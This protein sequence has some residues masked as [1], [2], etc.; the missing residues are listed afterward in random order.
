MAEHLQLLM[1]ELEEYRDH[2][3][4]LRSRMVVVPTVGIRSDLLS[5]YAESKRTEAA[6]WSV[7]TVRT[8]EEHLRH[9]W[10]RSRHEFK[11]YRLLT[12]LEF[13]Y[14]WMKA[15]LETLRTGAGDQ[16]EASDLNWMT[17]YVAR[18][19]DDSIRTWKLLHDY[20]I[21]RLPPPTNLLPPSKQRDDSLQ[22]LFFRWVCRYRETAC[23]HGW[24]SE[25]EL[26]ALLLDKLGSKNFMSRH[27]T[28]ALFL[29]LPWQEKI[30]HDYIREYVEAASAAGLD[31]QKR[32]LLTLPPEDV[33]E[34]RP[35]PRAFEY[36]DTNRE[37][38]AAAEQAREWLEQ[39]VDERLS[40]DE[41][42]AVRIG[43]VVPNLA[44][45]K[46]RMRRQFLATFCPNGH[47]ACQTPSFTIQ[48]RQSLADMTVCAEILS[49]LRILHARSIVYSKAR[50]LAH[51][52][53]FS[54]VV[55]KRRLD[56]LRE[57]TNHDQ[58]IDSEI[59]SPWRGRTQKKNLADWMKEFEDLL[60]E[61]RNSLKA[62]RR[63]DFR[64][65]F[66]AYLRTSRGLR[67]DRLI[68]E[69]TARDGKARK[70]VIGTAER[71]WMRG[72]KLKPAVQKR[73]RDLDA[74]SDNPDRYQVL[75]RLL[76]LEQRLLEGAEEEPAGADGRVLT[77]GEEARLSRLDGLIERLRHDSVVRRMLEIAQDLREVAVGDQTRMAFDEAYDHLS[78][79]CA[80]E[81]APTGSA[82]P[83]VGST[84]VEIVSLQ[85]ATGRRFSHL[86]FVG[87]RDT[88]WPP[89][90]RSNPLL[91]PGVL[92]ERA[93]SLFRPEDAAE[94]AEKAFGALVD[95]CDSRDNIR[96]SY[97]IRDAG[98]EREFLGA[99]RTDPRGGLGDPG[100]EEDGAET[101]EG[102]QEDAL[103]EPADPR[104]GITWKPGDTAVRFHPRYSADTP[105]A[106]LSPALLG[107]AKWST[108]LNE[109]VDP[110]GKER[111]WADAE[112]AT[113]F[114]CPFR[115]FAIHRLG[116]GARP[117]TFGSAAVSEPRDVVKAFRE[118]WER[119]G[120]RVVA[121]EG[122]SA[123]CSF[124]M[125]E[126]DYVVDCSIGLGGRYVPEHLKVPRSAGK[127][128]DHGAP[129]IMSWI[130]RKSFEE[131][132]QGRRLYPLRVLHWAARE[133][134]AVIPGYVRG[135]T[136]DGVKQA[137][138]R[139]EAEKLAD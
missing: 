104:E 121:V 137:H 1:G 66:G 87:L 55:P 29:T 54:G 75:E 123:M 19:C 48:A 41:T 138:R 72:G 21:D 129:L 94:C 15:G 16:A 26:A 76:A 25:P 61:C 40:R 42:R 69:F 9:V 107:A 109:R 117:R 95:C 127:K 60:E 115:A 45:V 23:K 101:E 49:Y 83:G 38:Q 27:G 71:E 62:R 112:Y 10:K 92:Q 52:G 80:T 78:S 51:A 47:W 3:E 36:A 108:G 86:W 33:P 17:K 30:R 105:G 18:V 122:G 58:D 110:E 116:I 88:D 99:D 56:K 28:P 124:K 11:G 90:V 130:M 77:V 136:L 65:V 120:L 35:E 67:L 7:P 13:R 119:E 8:W 96:L 59:R 32:C 81:P 133:S 118:K 22:A 103:A 98:L 20:R 111:K 63:A 12:P 128:G 97:A 57:H 74:L 125:D 68:E 135:E 73:V 6:C 53:R 134:E 85:Q 84:P 102:G 139:Q 113:Q 106:P 131:F 44:A 82:L 64:Q 14:H 126:E 31:A 100:D 2:R 37:L 43:I 79:A 132:T 39:A 93:P 24:L 46:H 91:D 4:V 70:L 34:G 5:L 89:P 50:A 114:E